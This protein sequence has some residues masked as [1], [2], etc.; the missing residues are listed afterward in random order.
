MDFFHG[1]TEGAQR[2]HE[3]AHAM[4][5]M[6]H[7]IPAGADAVACGDV[8]AG[9]MPNVEQAFAR[10]LCICLRDGVVT[11]DE[12]RGERADPRHGVPVGELAGFDSV[13]HLLHQLDIEWLARS[14]VDSE[15]HGVNILCDSS[16]VQVQYYTLSYTS[17]CSSGK[18][19]HLVHVRGAQ[20][21]R[22]VRIL[23]FRPFTVGTDTVL[24]CLVARSLFLMRTIPLRGTIC[25]T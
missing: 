4:A 6:A 8:C 18:S 20:C 19:R 21:D 13:P 12:L 9:A 23:I 24:L 10:Q 5:G 7:Q 11:D 16:T 3:L 22:F 25:T 14:S 1:E 15:E 2:S 17:V